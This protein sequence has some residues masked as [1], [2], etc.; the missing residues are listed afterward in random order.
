MMTKP[1]SDFCRYA[2]GYSDKER[3]QWPDGITCRD[4]TIKLLEEQLG[5]K[6]SAPQRKG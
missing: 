4:E 3:A 1:K 6:S 5:R 2:F